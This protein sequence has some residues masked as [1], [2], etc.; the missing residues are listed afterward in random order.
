MM[1]TAA[2]TL[3]ESPLATASEAP[4]PEALF[5]ADVLAGLARPQKQLAAKYFYDEIGSRLFDRITELDEYYPT[6][7]ERAILKRH[8]AGMAS[9]CGPDLLLIEPGAGSLVKVRHLLDHLDRPAAYVP[10][11]V[12]GE[13][14]HRA[15]RE[16]AV[17]YPG[18]PIRP[19]TADFTRPYGIPAIRASRRVIFF[20]GSTLGNF[21]PADADVLLRQMAR[22]V[23]SGGGVLLG[24]DLQ[25]DTATLEAAYDDAQGVTAAFNR[26]LLTRINRE[27]GGDFDVDAFTHRAVFNPQHSRIE[28]HL[29]SQA[30]QRV[31]ISDTVF[32]FRKGETIHTENSYK[33]NLL[34][35]RCRASRWNLRVDQTWTDERGYFALLYLVAR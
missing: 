13:H 31:R 14:L 2:H 5:R 11:D 30:N 17:D 23:G 20:P 6:R 10:V 1:L 19:V 32:S 35:L 26:N 12:S 29:V 27:L 16:L 25:K 4:S 22:Q 8:A 21:E 24:I 18:L 33:Y 3:T 15:A 9:R 28:M 7:T 34:D